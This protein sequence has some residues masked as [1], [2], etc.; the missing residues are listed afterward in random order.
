MALWLFIGA[1]F[2]ILL[3]LGYWVGRRRIVMT[4]ADQGLD[5]REEHRRADDAA[6]D[7]ARAAKA[8]MSPTQGGFSF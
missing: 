1:G 6:A 2:G 8:G 7:A 3:L 5:P 4:T